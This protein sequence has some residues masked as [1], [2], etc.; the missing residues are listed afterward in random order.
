MSVTYNTAALQCST[1]DPTSQRPFRVSG[2][3]TAS[4]RERHLA[5]CDDGPIACPLNRQWPSS[6]RQLEG[7][8]LWKRTFV[9]LPPEVAPAPD[10]EDGSPT[11]RPALGCASRGMTCRGVH[12][13][14]A[15]ALEE[16]SPP[17]EML[18]PTQSW[19]EAN[20]GQCNGDAAERSAIVLGGSSRCWSGS[21]HVPRWPWPMC[22]AR[23]VHAGSQNRWTSTTSCRTRPGWAAS[24]AGAP[25]AIVN[26]ELVRFAWNGAR[27]RYLGSHV[28]VPPKPRNKPATAAMTPCVAHRLRER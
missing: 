27:Q 12:L 19:R 10:P 2:A 18:C 21:S 28:I 17:S 14:A 4:P 16:R 26:A 20:P 11:D 15:R 9:R 7:H 24:G 3:R 6:D 1:L 23:A 25:P 13:P 8:G 5:I 22:S